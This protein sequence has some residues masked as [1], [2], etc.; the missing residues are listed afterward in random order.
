MVWHVIGPDPVNGISYCLLPLRG[1]KVNSDEVSIRGADM[2]S[3][4]TETRVQHMGY[5]DIYIN[6]V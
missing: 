2:K 3:L 1:K 6:P 4:T 5:R